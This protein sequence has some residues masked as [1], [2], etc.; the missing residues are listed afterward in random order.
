MFDL[1]LH[2][3]EG[4]AETGF[5]DIVL[6]TLLDGVKLIPFLFIAFLIIE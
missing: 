6:D 4:E 3:V 1:V 5:V 2:A